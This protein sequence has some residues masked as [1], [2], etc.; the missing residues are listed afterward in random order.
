MAPMGV[1]RKQTKVGLYFGIVKNSGG[2]RYSAIGNFQAAK[3]SDLNE[4]P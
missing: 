4:M 2:G 3:V 1:A